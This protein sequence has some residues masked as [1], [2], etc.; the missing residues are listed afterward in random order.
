MPK[1]RKAP[2]VGS[3]GETA[4]EG[5]AALDRA[6]A[7]LRSFSIA[8]PALTLAEIAARTGLYKSTILRL[9]ASLLHAQLIERLPDGRYRIGPAAFEL[10]TIYRRSITHTEVLLALMRELAD[11]L[12]E[13]VA[14][15]VRSGPNVRT[16]LLKVLSPRHTIYHYVQ[17]GDQL[18]C[19]VGSGGRVLLAFSGEK[20]A[21]NEAARRDFFYV[22]IG[23][24]DAETSGVS[25]PV[26]GPDHTLLGALTVSGPCSRF[27]AAFIA[28]VTQRL[29]LMA[30][31]ATHGVGGDVTA[32]ELAAR[33]LLTPQSDAPRTGG[34]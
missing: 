24:R 8:T 27:D 9:G 31:R 17:E 22:S 19:D 1:A 14:F 15:S 26:F 21:L 18:P 16:C 23:E 28:R 29:L 2:V 34:A 33:K 20:G 11:D 25:A 30:V 13:S 32:L 5:V 4:P 12:G 6:I 3:G 10:G 7:I